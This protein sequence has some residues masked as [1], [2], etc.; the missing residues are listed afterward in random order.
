MGDSDHKPCTCPQYVAATAN[1]KVCGVLAFGRDVF[2][3]C[4]ISKGNV[5]F[6]F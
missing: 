4:L 3:H 6:A 2:V 1:A 5:V